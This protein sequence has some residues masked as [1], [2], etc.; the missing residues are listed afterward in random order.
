MGSTSFRCTSGQALKPIK[1]TLDCLEEMA[2][3]IPD[4]DLVYH[5]L[6]HVDYRSLA[7]LLGTPI[8]WL[9]SHELALPPFSKRG[10]AF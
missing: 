7:A 4:A 9:K 10:I 6:I 3:Q 8:H 2:A 5:L 1:L